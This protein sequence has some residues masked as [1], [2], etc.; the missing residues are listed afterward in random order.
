M[1]K[2]FSIEKINPNESK[3]YVKSAFLGSWSFTLDSLDYD[4]LCLKLTRY[5]SNSEMIQDI[6]PELTSNQRECFITDP[7]M[8]LF[9]EDIPDEI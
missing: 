2:T 8:S 9:F 3:V 4:T 1:K 5:C 7:K 6:F